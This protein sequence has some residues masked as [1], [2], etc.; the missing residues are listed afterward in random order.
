[1]EDRNKQLEERIRGVQR[2]F[3]A[4]L[5]DTI[6]S[7]DIRW[8]TL[9][10]TAWDAQGAQE[11]QSIAHRLAGSGGTFGFPDISQTAAVLDVS[12]GDAL[13]NH[14]DIPPE[15]MVSLERQVDDLLC[16][17]KSALTT[18]EVAFADFPMLT[19][20]VESSQGLIVVIDDDAFLLERI[21]ALLEGAGFSVATFTDPSQAVALLQVQQPVLILLDLMF[22]GQRWPAFEVIADLRGETGQRTPVA[23]ISGR[24]DFRSRLQATRA[25]ADAYFVKPL[26]DRQLVEAVTQLVAR[27]STDSWRCLVI[28]DDEILSQQL[29]E[30]L[31]EAHMTAEW[32]SSPSESWLQVREFRPDVLI[33]DINM[34]ECNGI[35][36]ATMLRQDMSSS[37]L[38]IV[39]LTAD[40]AELTR[41][42]AM[43]A[44]ADDYLLKPINREA[45]IKAVIARAKLG[46]RMQNQV[47]LITQQAPEGG[48]GLSRHFFF[49]EFER[50]I[51][52]AD[53]GAVQSALVLIGLVAI[54]EVLANYG[55]FGLA[56]IHEQLISHLSNEKVTTWSMLGENIVGILLPRAT[57]L[58][59]QTSVK[60]MLKR[61]SA[62]PY[63]VNGKEVD[64]GAC[65][66]ILH[67]RN[68]QTAAASI[69]LQAEQMLS[70]AIETGVGTVLDGFVGTSEAV[71]TTGR[72]P[73]ERLQ[74]VFQSIM[75]MAAENSPVSTVL[76]RIADADGNLLP[77]GKFLSALEK[78]GWLP[79][80]DAWVFR[81]AHH[82]LT[83][84][85]AVDE[86]QCL[87]VHASPSSLNSAIYHETV[88][89]I[90][91][92]HPMR[93]K[94]QSIVIAIPEAVAITHRHMVEKLNNA[95]NA[96]GG[97][98]M[99]TNYGASA[100]SISVLQQL[101]PQYV[102][103]DEALT[104]R[105]EKPE[106]LPADRTL[107]ETTTAA[108]T[109][110]VASGIE[111]AH[112]LSGL[113][114]KGIRWFQGYFIQEPNAMLAVASEDE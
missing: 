56:A 89:T 85:I 47:S 3:I 54:S 53:D 60:G 105:L 84:Q 61:L 46:K 55:A 77:A 83:T 106:Y 66:A 74:V 94:L 91:D 14:E 44:G 23:V 30:W 88:L 28:D 38:P 5:P 13:K 31:R 57:P 32:V 29:V 107:I 20:R 36:F 35:E 50:V 33:L 79:E 63:H 93:S 11:L 101:N 102:R 9:R 69:L 114:A 1:M 22:P 40:N 2:N 41:R 113:W 99:I 59:H 92:E 80:L 96:A 17:L 39:F 78:R 87:I 67:L 18:A 64:S 26:D 70:V 19:S 25:G 43:A 72:L 103:L 42:D 16:V 71:E 110:I 90:L 7:L 73:I 4:S 12:L 68:A 45:L 76:A 48:G 15:K 21:S 98:L 100:S 81:K 52:E 24:A 104:R 58:E 108:N 86:A 111:N 27:S 95:L 112:S 97:G 65:A 8:K 10:H 49:N 109:M 6:I 75:S 62:K 34:P 82:L 51:D 37:Q